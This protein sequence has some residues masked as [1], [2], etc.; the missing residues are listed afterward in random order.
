[1]N[2]QDFAAAH[3]RGLYAITPAIAESES[4][5][6]ESDEKLRRMCE[7]ALRGGAGVLQY[8]D[9]N[10]AAQTKTRRAQMLKELCA[11]YGAIFIINDDIALAQ[12]TA[13][14]GVHLGAADCRIAAARAECGARMLIGATCGG[15]IRRALRAR[16]AGADYCAFGA[17]FASQTKPDA[18]QCDLTTLSD[19]KQKLN[20][21]IVAVGGITPQNAARVFAAGADAVAVCAGIFAAADIKTAAR[22]IIAA[23][24]RPS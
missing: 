12:N 5:D 2:R 23:Q 11:G 15:D 4:A 1:M 13:A 7:A 14:D 6:L 3:L 18:R 24:I 16:A 20:L 21:P 10:A 17:I 9:K 22:K 19:A 8:R